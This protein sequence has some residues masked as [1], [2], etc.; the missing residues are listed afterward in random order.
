M[1]GLGT[2]IDIGIGMGSSSEVEEEEENVGYVEGIVRVWH[3][4]SV[5][6]T[7]Y[8]ITTYNS[9]DRQVSA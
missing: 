5:S 8:I 6:Y 4:Q 7:S 2:I 3:S 9:I 1:S